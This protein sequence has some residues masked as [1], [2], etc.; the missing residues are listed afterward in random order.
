MPS[1]A[2]SS[3]IGLVFLLLYSML[4]ASYPYLLHQEN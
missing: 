1:H 3:I 4:D 2:K